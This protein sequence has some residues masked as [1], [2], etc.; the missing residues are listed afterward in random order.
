MPRVI[1][2]RQEQTDIWFLNHVWRHPARRALFLES[3]PGDERWLSHVPERD[4]PRWA[5]P[6]APRR[7]FKMRLR[8]TAR[9]VMEDPISYDLTTQ[10]PDV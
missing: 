9:R 3:V 5:A 4:F 10:D 6:K 1:L 7:K 2:Y 8:D